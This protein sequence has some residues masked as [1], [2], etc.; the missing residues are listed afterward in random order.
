MLAKGGKIWN[1]PSVGTGIP[2][3]ARRERFDRTKPF[4][5]I[6]DTFELVVGIAVIIIGIVGMVKTFP[7]IR[8]ELDKIFSNHMNTYVEKGD[9]LI[10]NFYDASHIISLTTPF[11][12]I[13]G[14]TL[15]LTALF[16]GSFFFVFLS[17]LPIFGAIMLFSFAGMW[18]TTESSAH[19]NEWVSKQTDGGQYLLFTNDKTTIMKDGKEIGTLT[20]K[21]S[22]NG[23]TTT[24]TIKYYSE[25]K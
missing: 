10:T 12:F 25:E 17:S 5:F 15:L 11:I 9:S 22:K 19:V 7:A 24:A 2:M 14:G 13:A 23:D 3:P 18:A 16:R 21:D 4:S 6:G 8:Q 1:H 20:L